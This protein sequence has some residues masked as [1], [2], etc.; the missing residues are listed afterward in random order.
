MTKEEAINELE[1]KYPWF[2]PITVET[3]F[4]QF[5]NWCCHIQPE[6]CRVILC[7]SEEEAITECV[8]KYYIARKRCREFNDDI[9]DY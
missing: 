5:L 3:E 6:H 1:T 9:D 2:K 7:N 4:N 8:K